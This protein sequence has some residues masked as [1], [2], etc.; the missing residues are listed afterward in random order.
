M[1]WAIDNRWSAGGAGVH[2]PEDALAAYGA[3]WIDR[4]DLTPAE[5]LPDRQGFAYDNPA[6]R[7]R[8]IDK[9]ASAD[10]T[11]REPSRWPSGEYDVVH[12]IIHRADWEVW[13]RR[14]GGYIYVAAW[15]TPP[16]RTYTEDEL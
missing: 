2:T 10:G 15:L 7:D 4:G 16:L 5:I 14:A 11:I 8:L 1:T 6:D 9:L 12:R 3:R 13:V